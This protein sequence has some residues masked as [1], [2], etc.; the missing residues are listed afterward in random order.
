MFVVGLVGGDAFRQRRAVGPHLFNFV[1]FVR[2]VLPFRGPAFH[3]RMFR[4]E[5]D[6]FKW[7]AGLVTVG[8][9]AKHLAPLVGLCFSITVN[10]TMN[11]HGGGTPQKSLPKVLDPIYR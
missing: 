2:L 1:K 3:D 10:R 7:P 11:D 8:T 9:D 5:T 4:L 6:D